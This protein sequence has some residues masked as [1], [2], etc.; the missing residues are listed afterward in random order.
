LSLESTEHQYQELSENEFRKLF[1]EL[2]PAIRNFLYFKVGDTDLAEDLAQD[3]F[4]KIWDNRARIDKRTLKSYT[5]TIAGNL[6][7]NHLKRQQ[8]QYRFVSEFNDDRGGE[9]PEAGMIR[10]E[11][12]QKLMSVL[13][14][15]P[16]GSREVFMM[17]R[18][19]DLKY[20]DIADRLGISVK[21]VE[22]RMSKALQIIREKLN[23]DL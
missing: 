16:E 14:S 12:E 4:V 5:Y 13:G 1:D 20:K 17:N 11:Y 2:F 9:S 8:L 23:V 19:E 18:I 21:A 3:T 15:I 6:A 22:K 7:I 10:A